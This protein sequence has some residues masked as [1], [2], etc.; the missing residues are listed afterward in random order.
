VGVCRESNRATPYGFK[1]ENKKEIKLEDFQDQFAI[2]FTGP[3]VT[4]VPTN[5]L[6]NFLTNSEILKEN[7][8]G[9]MN[10]SGAS[11]IGIGKMGFDVYRYD[12]KEELKGGSP[13]NVDRYIIE[14]VNGSPIMTKIRLPDGEHKLSSLPDDFKDLTSKNE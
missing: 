8:A 3:N 12:K 10:L 11:V 9:V 6:P 4:A 14:M 2:H 13:I 5:K 1:M 7:T